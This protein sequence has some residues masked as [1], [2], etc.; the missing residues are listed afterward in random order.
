ML[1]MEGQKNRFSESN[2]RMHK[3]K[4]IDLGV[5]KLFDFYPFFLQM[6]ADR[7][8]DRLTDRYTEL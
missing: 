1:Y 7:W 8:T 5:K 4:S 6:C 2:A 3:D